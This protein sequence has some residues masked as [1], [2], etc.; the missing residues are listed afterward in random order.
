MH[1]IPHCFYYSLI[2]VSGLVNHKQRAKEISRQVF[3]NSLLMIPIV[4]LPIDPSWVA[5]AFDCEIV[6]CRGKTINHGSTKTQNELH[7]TATP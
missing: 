7:T 1:P 6:H 4:A 5:R 2:A 3:S